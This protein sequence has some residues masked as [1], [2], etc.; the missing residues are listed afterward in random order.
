MAVD[1]INKI[2]RERERDK[3]GTN[4]DEE[5]WNELREETILAIT[6]TFAFRSLNLFTASS[7]NMENNSQSKT[8]A[9]TK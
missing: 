3:G 4:A 5:R 9:H 2:E 7:S 8:H 1:C 6:I